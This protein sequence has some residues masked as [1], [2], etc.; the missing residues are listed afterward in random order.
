MTTL[1]AITPTPSD[2]AAISV[3]TATFI[4]SI[5]TTNH[6]SG[7]DTAVPATPMT[8]TVLVYL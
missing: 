5:Y 4:V 1:Y 2:S 3:D 6:D 8:Y 7:I